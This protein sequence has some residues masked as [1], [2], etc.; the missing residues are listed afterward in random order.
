MIASSPL[1]QLIAALMIAAPAAQ[2]GERGQHAATLV[3]GPTVFLLIEARDAAS[4]E[5]GVRSVVTDKA[6]AGRLVIVAI[7]PRDV[8]AAQVLEQVLPKG[9]FKPRTPAWVWRPGHG[10]TQVRGARISALDKAVGHIEAGS[11]ST[12]AEAVI[13]DR[14][15]EADEVTRFMGPLMQRTPVITYSIAALS[16]V[17]FALQWWWGNGN[18]YV[19]APR[20][21]GAMKS[22]IFEGQ[23]WRLVA[24]MLL[25]GSPVH[26]AL[27][28]MGLLSFGIFLER[29]LGPRRYLILYVASGLGGGIAS[30]LR[31]TEVIS[32]GASGGIWGLMVAGAV[33]VTWPRG[34]LPRLVTASQRERA[35]APV[36]INGAYSL[37]PGIDLLAHFGGGFIGGVL[38]LTGAL[39]AGMPSAQE[40]LAR[41]GQA[42]DGVLVRLTAAVLGLALL[43]GVGTA[44]ALGR[45]WEL[46]SAPTLRRVSIDAHW[47]IEMPAAMAMR[48]S[49]VGAVIFGSLREDPMLIALEA[50]PNELSEAQAADP[51][52]TLEALRSSSNDEPPLGFHAAVPLEMREREGRPYLFT[53]LVASDS[54]NS[55][56][57][58]LIDGSH[59]LDVMVLVT[60]GTSAE[61]KRAA[62][63]IPFTARWSAS[64]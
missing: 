20:M 53:E 35:W 10:L 1:D 6:L 34:L 61:W 3:F 62:E 46:R 29:F 11:V 49:G 23:V 15:N 42:R 24:P 25:H 59:L 12:S 31:S 47:S 16:V 13:G 2:L 18:P 39:T 43:G 44:L 36:L 27:N 57:Y 26:L 48:P 30:A 45:P 5:A 64:P 51:R 22:L 7:E 14:G 9:L 4:L 32:V 40:A 19:S 55:Q 38:M 8:G 60:D 50:N 21:G 37:Q 63:Q 28:M 41:P 17:L 56:T 58:R 33:L 52:A 54:R